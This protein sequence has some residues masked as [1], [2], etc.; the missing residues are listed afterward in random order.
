MTT[1]VSVALGSLLSSFVLISMA[2]ANPS[3]MACL[4]TSIV[5]K[6]KFAA[7]SYKYKPQHDPRNS[8]NRVMWASGVLL[9]EI[10]STV[11]FQQGALLGGGGGR[12]RCITAPKK[13]LW[14]SLFQPPGSLNHM[15]SKRFRERYDSLFAFGRARKKV[16]ARAK[17][18]CEEGRGEKVGT[19]AA[20]KTELA[21]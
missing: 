7:P 12:K 9:I 15:H 6:D 21:R 20:R 4:R 8:C 3:F 13:W 11:I 14:R 1:A 2:R 10:K 19:Q 16:R 18:K 17:T 5:E